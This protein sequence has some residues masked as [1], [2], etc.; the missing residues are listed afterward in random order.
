MVDL[1]MK[2]RI[3]SW[4]YLKTMETIEKGNVKE[5]EHHWEAGSSSTSIK[6]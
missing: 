3:V 4:V 1:L 2:D 5:R 6:F